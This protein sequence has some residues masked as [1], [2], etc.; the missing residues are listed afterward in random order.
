[1]KKSINSITPVA[2]LLLAA[3]L[4]LPGFLAPQNNSIPTWHL[5]Y[6]N[7]SL[8]H[9]LYG[10]K[11]DLINAVKRGSPVRVAWGEKLDDG[12]SDVE[13]S[14]PEFTTLVNDSD[15]VIQLPASMIQTDY[16]NAKRSFLKTNPPTQWRG[17]M[18]TDGHYHQ[19][20]TEFKTGDLKRVMW[21]KTAVAWYVFAPEHDNSY[22]PQLTIRNGI[23][24]DSIKR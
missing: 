9:A 20:H 1:M 18:S 17:L 10:S 19:F 23:H 7:D 8:G 24:L 15:L 21:L 13:F 4:I 11:K 2:L 5:V 16:M 3:C 14:T 12:T 6:Q 22:I